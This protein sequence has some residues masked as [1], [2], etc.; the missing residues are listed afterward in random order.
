[1]QEHALGLMSLPS[2]EKV[3]GRKTQLRGRNRPHQLHG[4]ASRDPV[5]I[6]AVQEQDPAGSRWRVQQKRIPGEAGQVSWLGGKTSSAQFGEK[7][8][9]FKKTDTLT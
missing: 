5:V 6:R 3:Q 9:H 4:G 8:R 2:L 1:M 7:W